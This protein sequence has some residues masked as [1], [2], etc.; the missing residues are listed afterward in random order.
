M[1]IPTPLFLSQRDVA[2]APLVLTPSGQFEGNDG[3]WSTFNVQV[4]TPPQNFRVMISTATSEIWVPTLQQCNATQA[5]CGTLHGVGAFQGHAESNGFQSNGSSTW[6]FKETLNLDLEDDLGFYGTAAYGYDTVS[7][8]ETASPSLD[9]QLV[10]DMDSQ[11]YYFGILGINATASEATSS[12]GKSGFFQNLKDQGVIPSLSYGY[13]AGAPYGAANVSGTLVLGGYDQSRFT[14]SG[15]D[16]PF[17]SD[18]SG[19]FTVGVQSVLGQDTFAGSASFYTDGYWAVID[20]TVPEVWLPRSAC[21][22]M[23]QV[24]KLTYDNVTDLYL[25]DASTRS[26]L[27]TLNPSFT[28]KLGPWIYGG[29]T[30]EIKLPYAA[31]DQQISEPKYSNSTYYF[32]VRRA[33]NDSQLVLG[34]TFLQGA[35]LIADYERKTF[36]VNAANFSDPMPDQNIVPISSLSSSS[37]NTTSVASSPEGGLSTGAMA[38]L[39]VGAAALVIALLAL[40][41]FLW[42]RS[43]RPPP[44]AVVPLEKQV[45]RVELPYDDGARYEAPAEAIRCELGA[46]PLYHELHTDY[47]NGGK[48]LYASDH[49]GAN[50]IHELPGDGRYVQAK[51]RKQKWRLL[52]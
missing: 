12:A 28:F 9:A 18:G 17:H 16:F 22:L 7:L 6:Q 15:F 25:V 1:P 31:F 14:S 46:A 23:E 19:S 27:Q 21:D 39:G 47:S 32:P 43:K 45:V 36:S 38:G 13:T 26:Q 24:L 49:F 10:A 42:K 20:S 11:D 33:T 52:R 41:I 34:R 48:V 8:G 37:G 5:E 2:P 40:F 4:G 29:N 44:A 3:A 51:P 35:Y 30:T 50:T